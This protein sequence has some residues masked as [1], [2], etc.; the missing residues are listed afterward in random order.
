MLPGPIRRG[1]VEQFMECADMSALLKAATCRCTPNGS[2][3]E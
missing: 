2:E 3:Q 1:G